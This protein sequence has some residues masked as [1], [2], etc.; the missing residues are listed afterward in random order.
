MMRYTSATLLS[1][2][3]AIPR[4]A[5]RRD[6]FEAFARAVRDHLAE[7]WTRTV[8]TYERQNPKMIYYL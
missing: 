8:K 6:Q 7:R 1:T 2:T 4:A 5:T 3:P